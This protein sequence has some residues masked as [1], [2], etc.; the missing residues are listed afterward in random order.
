MANIP[1]RTGITSIRGACRAVVGW[2]TAFRPVVALFLPEP[3]M[4]KWD[5]L[6]VA[7]TEFLETVDN[8]RPGDVYP[9]V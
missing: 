2:L 1:Y 6:L 4:A 7:A 5:A 8:P 9:P 3:Q